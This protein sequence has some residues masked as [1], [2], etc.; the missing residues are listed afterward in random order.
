MIPTNA[1]F[2]KKLSLPHEIESRVV[3]FN[4][5][6]KIGCFYATTD[7]DG[8]VFF[9]HVRPGIYKFIIFTR[10]M[11]EVPA[12]AQ[13]AKH[14]LSKYFTDESVELL[15]HFRTDSADVE[16]LPGEEIKK[17]YHFD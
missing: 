17:A 6:D 2:A 8:D 15:L 1:E 10:E 9:N 14:I 5:R 13:R 4:E 16:I 3:I 11:I 7:A 12:Q